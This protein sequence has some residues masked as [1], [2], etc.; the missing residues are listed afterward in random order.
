M[1]QKARVSS[2]EP[3]RLRAARERLEELDRSFFQCDEPKR[4]PRIE[5]KAPGLLRR[6]WRMLTGG[7]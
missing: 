4:A 1:G 5:A 6:W 3:R 2:F 7:E